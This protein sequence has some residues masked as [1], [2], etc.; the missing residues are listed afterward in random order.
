MIHPRIALSGEITEWILGS[1]AED[2]DGGMLPLGEIARAAHVRASG[3]PF[4]A[5]SP[6]AKTPRAKNSPA[7]WGSLVSGNPDSWGAG[8]GPWWLEEGGLARITAPHR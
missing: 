7:V 1:E 4:P 3:P 2:D 8:N 5:P 6:H